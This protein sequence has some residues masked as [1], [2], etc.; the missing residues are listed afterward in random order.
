M[1]IQSKLN[2]A[3][4]YCNEE[5]FEQAIILFN[6]IIMTGNAGAEVYYSRARAHFKLNRLDDCLLDF[7][8]VLQL[9]PDNAHWLSERAVAYLLKGEPQKALQDLDRAAAL[10]PENPYRY[11]SRAFI[12][13]RIGDYHGAIADYEMAIKLDPE[14]AIAYNNKGLVEEKIGWADKA[15]TSYAIADSLDPSQKN[16]PKPTDSPEGYKAANEGELAPLPKIQADKPKPDKPGAADY[17]KVIKETLTT[18]KGWSEFCAF[19]KQK[20]SGK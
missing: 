8:Q 17:L 15:K 12:K 10:E 19:V 4:Q 16:R 14:D 2:Q 5:Q 18:S 9:S 7:D 3:H 1:D 11:S 6:E 13:D 20:L